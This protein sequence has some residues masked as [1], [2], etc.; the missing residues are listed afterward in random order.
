MTD[1]N[2]AKD[3]VVDGKNGYIVKPDVDEIVKAIRKFE[4]NE[5]IK[6]ISIETFDSFDP[7]ASSPETY[8]KNLTEVYE[9][10]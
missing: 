9:K 6:Q 7:K 2:S 8:I 1:C 10:G 4:D 5:I 3:T